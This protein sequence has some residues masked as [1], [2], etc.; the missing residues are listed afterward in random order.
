MCHLRDMSAWFIHVQI[1][2][3]YNQ[4]TVQH[5]SPEFF[6]RVGDHEILPVANFQ[7]FREL[8]VP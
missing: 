2:L 8:L 7:P 3:A 4:Y 1:M 6:L 5:V